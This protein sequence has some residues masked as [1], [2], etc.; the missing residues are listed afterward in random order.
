[1]VRDETVKITLQEI[2]EMCSKIKCIE[3]SSLHAEEKKLCTAAS[4]AVHFS[5]KRLLYLAS[6]ST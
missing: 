5:Y 1:M 3:I 4:T 2:H 6:S